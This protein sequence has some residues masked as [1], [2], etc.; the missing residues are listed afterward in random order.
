MCDAA[1][2]QLRDDANALNACSK[3]QIEPRQ[4][5]N[6]EELNSTKKMFE[7]NKHIIVTLH[8]HW[9][10]ARA[11][12]STQARSTDHRKVELRRTDFAAE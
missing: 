2:V 5:S 9:Q 6:Q 8:S 10:A 12:N 7:M 3:H 11:H 1:L 4:E